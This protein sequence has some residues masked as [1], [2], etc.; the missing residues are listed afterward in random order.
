M[1]AP[2]AWAGR[3]LLTCQQGPSWPGEARQ[4]PKGNW[5][6]FK[7]ELIKYDFAAPAER[8]VAK[9]QLCCVFGESRI[10]YHM[11]SSYKKSKKLLMPPRGLFSK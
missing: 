7:A 3:L 11:K 2:S 10:E 6:A 8:R 4:S 9:E 5:M 1:A